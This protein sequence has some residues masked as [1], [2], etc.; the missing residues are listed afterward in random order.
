MS[1]DVI[2][3]DGSKVVLCM[4][5]SLDHS[6]SGRGQLYIGATHFSRPGA[7][8]ISDY[9][10]TKFVMVRLLARDISTDPAILADIA[11]LTKRT[12]DWIAMAFAVGPTET[13]DELRLFE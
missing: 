1:I 10:H 12:S 9:D 2:R 4:S 13:L 6:F 8:R 7:T 5:N 3:P 11:I